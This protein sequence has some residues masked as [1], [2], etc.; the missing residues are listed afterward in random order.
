VHITPIPPRM[1][2]IGVRP[3]V[4]DVAG[5][6]ISYPSLEGRAKAKKC[7]TATSSLKSLFGFGR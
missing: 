6:E 4:L 5:D 2:S 1:T 7:K 3:I